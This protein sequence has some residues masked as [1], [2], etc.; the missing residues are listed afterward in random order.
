MLISLLVTKFHVMPKYIIRFSCLGYFER[1]IIQ[2][3]EFV[4]F[5][6]LSQNKGFIML[7][8]KCY[9]GFTY[10]FRQSRC[11]IN[12]LLEFMAKL[13]ILRVDDLDLIW[14]EL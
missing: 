8:L 7:I 12:I 10:K 9:E 6:R 5:V 4:V 13:N 3:Y 14:Y 11:C 2:S 1:L